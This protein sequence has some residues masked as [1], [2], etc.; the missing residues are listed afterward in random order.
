MQWS[1][2]SVEHPYKALYKQ[3]SLENVIFNEITQ[4]DINIC[5]WDLH[6]V[7]A[8]KR[9]TKGEMISSFHRAP[10]TKLST[11]KKIKEMP[12]LIELPKV[13]L[14]FVSEIFSK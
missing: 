9:F 2:P 7:A 11:R 14:K 13:M 1:A 10:S 4:I 6:K 12:S 3:S 5:Q 8:L